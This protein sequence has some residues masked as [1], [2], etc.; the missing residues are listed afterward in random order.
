MAKAKRYIPEGLSTV[1]PALIVD[2]V[3]RAIAW[4]K[5]VF[6]ATEAGE[7]YLM[8]DGKVA[9][10]EVRIGSSTLFLSDPMAGTPDAYRDGRTLGGSPVEL[11]LYVEDCDYV[12]QRAVEN[13]ARVNM[14]LVDQFWGDRWGGFTDPFGLNWSVATRKEDLSPAEMR[15]RG[16]EFFR[17]MA[18]QK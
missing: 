12:Y 7:R 5:T 8:P 17:K 1:T 4:Y 2:G 11:S 3:D 10:A 15:A 14:P 13:G 6:G 18:A 16:D 9:H